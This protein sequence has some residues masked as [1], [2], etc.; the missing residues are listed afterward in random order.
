M[1]RDAGWF[2]DYD[3]V[4]VFMEDGDGGRG[5][6]GFVAVEGV[7]DYVAVFD[8]V[9]CGYGFA[10]YDYDAALYGFF[11]GFFTLVSAE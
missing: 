11:L 2:V 1:D 9:V 7:G 5:D 8:D 3:H 4:G 10:V 6:W